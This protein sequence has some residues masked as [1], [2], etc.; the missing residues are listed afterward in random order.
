MNATDVAPSRWAVA[1]QEALA[2]VAALGPEDSMTVIRAAERAGGAGQ[3]VQRPALLRRA[4]L[5]AQPSRPR[6][7][8]RRR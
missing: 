6:R 8:G 5:G 1:Q 2:I 7:T 3:R 4:I